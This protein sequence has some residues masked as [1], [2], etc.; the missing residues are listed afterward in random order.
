MPIA[1]VVCEIRAINVGIVRQS[2]EGGDLRERVRGYGTHRDGGIA[3]ARLPE[4]SRKGDLH[5]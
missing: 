4:T 3:T 2:Y 1:R 5:V